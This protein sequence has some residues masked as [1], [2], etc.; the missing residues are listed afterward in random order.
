[1]LNGYV[2][3]PLDE[4]TWLNMQASMALVDQ[5]MDEHEAFAGIQKGSQPEGGAARVFQYLGRFF[6][7]DNA[8][9]LVSGRGGHGAALAAERSQEF[10]ENLSRAPHVAGFIKLALIALFPWLVFPVVAGH[11]QRPRLLVPP[12]LFGT[13][14]DADLDAPLPHHGRHLAFDRGDGG[15][16]QAS[17]WGV[18]LQRQPDHNP[19]ELYVR[20]LLVAPACGRG[21]FHRGMVWVLRPVIGDTGRDDQPEFIGDARGALATGTKAAGAAAAIL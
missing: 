1:M 9:S 16:R 12:V 13:P 14:L 15:I 11:W 5:Y 18:A 19:H 17:R 4:T 21:G 20:G 7:W 8:A 3:Y 10:S 6:S 2:G